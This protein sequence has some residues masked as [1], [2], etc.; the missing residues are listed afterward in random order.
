[1]EKDDIPEAAI[2]YMAAWNETDA[3]AREALL[4][5]CWGDHAVYVD[6]GVELSGREALSRHIAQVQA[7]RPGA[8]LEFMSGIDSH[9]N[10]LRF[11][12]R[13][14]RADGTAGDPSIDFGEIG[15][16]GRL[17]KIVG[18]FGPAPAILRG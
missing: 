4:E 8:R 17:V 7:G 13:L 15:P 1:M 12:W 2:R 14:V 3:S 6:P 18:F 10:V 9:H 11:L 16:D 5:Q